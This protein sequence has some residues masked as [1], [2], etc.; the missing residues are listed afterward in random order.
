M[1]YYCEAGGDQ[2]GDST[3]IAICNTRAMA[4]TWLKDVSLLG[5]M[6]HRRWYYDYDYA[7]VKK[8]KMNTS[9]D[10]WKTEADWEAPTKKELKYLDPNVREYYEMVQIPPGEKD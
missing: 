6:R 1:I 5:H 2:D 8:V 3:L 7:Y 9:L 10:N 4:I